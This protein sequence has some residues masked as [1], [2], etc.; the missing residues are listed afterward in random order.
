M[1]DVVV[2]DFVEEMEVF[3]CEFGG[4]GEFVCVEIGGGKFCEVEGVDLVGIV[5]G[6]VSGF[7]VG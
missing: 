3:F 2:F 7:C 5:G 1:M 4:I 6:D